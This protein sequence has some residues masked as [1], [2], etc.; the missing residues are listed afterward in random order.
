[1]ERLE[2]EMRKLS[3]NIDSLGMQ[4]SGL[5]KNIDEHKTSVSREEHFLKENTETLK[6]NNR[7]QLAILEQN[8]ISQSLEIYK[9]FNLGK[10]TL[11]QAATLL[12]GIMEATPREAWGIGIQKVSGNIAEDLNN[13]RNL[14]KNDNESGLNQ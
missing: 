8:A 14:N 1:M 9:M 6:K 3:G 4:I 2:L 7:L 13:K 12:N 11:N 10:I 5:R